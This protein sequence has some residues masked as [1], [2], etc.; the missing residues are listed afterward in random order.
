ML[1][2]TPPPGDQWTL[3]Q[4]SSGPSHS[5]GPS[6]LGGTSAQSGGPPAQPQGS[7]ERTRL[8][9]QSASGSGSGQSGGEG[10]SGGTDSLQKG[11][12]S[13]APQSGAS[14]NVGGVARD[15]Q[16]VR[17][18]DAVVKAIEVAKTY[19]IMTDKALAYCLLSIH[20]SLI[21]HFEHH[22]SAQ[23][24][25]DEAMGWLAADN[26]QHIHL[27]VIEFRALYMLDTES[28]TEWF[29][30]LR[31]VAGKLIAGGQQITEQEGV[32][33][34]IMG[35]RHA[36]FQA[37]QQSVIAARGSLPY[38]EVLDMY[39]R[40]ERLNLTLP[41]GSPFFPT[42]AKSRSLNQLL[43]PPVQV[44]GFIAPAA[45]RGGGSHNPGRGRGGG[46]AGRGRGR[47]GA[48]FCTHCKAN[49]H[50]VDRC[51]ALHEHLRPKYHT[52]ANAGR[53]EGSTAARGH[54]APVSRRE[55]DALVTQMSGWAYM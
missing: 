14:Q 22:T 48:L 42:Y 25:Y 45:G 49:G 33:Y 46:A 8:R 2:K 26:K 11:A 28:V 18:I 40:A 30:R 6:I 38:S 15:T 51:W 39:E 23:S 17:D 50:L 31:R 34:A 35:A 43:P 9:R 44:P 55:F 24:I 12:D 36:R 5:R 20:E 54:D 47:G 37:L 27:L 19:R 3:G 4:S 53:G 41:T 32:Q 10:K 52:P 21:P 7:P 13:S 29:D 1:F 16:D